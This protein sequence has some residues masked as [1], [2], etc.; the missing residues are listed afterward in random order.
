MPIY[1]DNYGSGL[2]AKRR[3]YLDRVLL[4][5]ITQNTIYEKLATI[6]K[7]LPLKNSKVIEFEKWIT[8]K[9]LYWANNINKQFTGN[10]HTKG[11]ETLLMIDKDAYQDFILDEGSSGTSKA[12]MELIK[13][14]ATVFLIG[15]WMPYTEE[16]ELF[17]DRWS[18]AEAVRQM[19][20]MATMIL[21]G[22]YRDLYASSAGHFFDETTAG[23]VKD[24]TFTSV[25]KRLISQ[26]KLS[27]CK[28]VKSIL[29]SSPN[30]GTVPVQSFFIAY[31]H[32]IAIDDLENNPDWIPLEKYSAGIT[33]L[34]GERGMIGKIRYI[35]DA[36]AYIEPTGT[37]GEYV[38]EFIIAGDRH[39]ASVPLRGKGAVQSVLHE[40]GS[41]G[42]QDPLN[43]VGTLGYKV[44]IGAK[45]I[46]Q[47]N[48]GCIR[49]TFNY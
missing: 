12:Q 48:L 18:T 27:G 13:T 33:P 16:L 8:A 6:N 3:A 24:A 47:Q 32:T 2:G 5:N 28:P 21:D 42:T 30:Y 35:E 15:D 49:A 1:G 23:N 29:S 40:I 20:E 43:R 11:E 38:A 26:L 22:F 19:S 37:A 10:D 7:P 25:N 31:G 17:H 44:W 41:S 14:E 45:S 34:P 4:E 46:Y 9:E 36:N 39:T